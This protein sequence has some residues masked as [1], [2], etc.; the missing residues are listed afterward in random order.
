MP[1]LLIVPRSTK[2]ILVS[3]CK[4]VCPS[5]WGAPGCSPGWLLSILTGET[6][7]YRVTTFADISSYYLNVLLFY[8]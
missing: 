1:S 5:F 7:L 2:C 6:K 3:A 8:H 4:T